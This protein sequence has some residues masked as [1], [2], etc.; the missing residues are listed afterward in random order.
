MW[1]LTTTLR[2]GHNQVAPYNTRASKPTTMWSPTA[3]VGGGLQPCALQH[4]PGRQVHKNVPPTTPVGRL[5]TKCGPPQ[6]QWASGHSNVVPRQG[7]AAHNHVVPYN[8]RGG[9]HEHPKTHNT[10]GRHN[11][12][13]PPQH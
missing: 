13:G 7:E 12:H 6:H 5:P 3:P 2:K 11:N 8:S 4:Q 10:S 9:A 1:P